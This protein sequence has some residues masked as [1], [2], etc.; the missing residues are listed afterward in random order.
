[1]Y[2]YAWFISFAL[3]AVC[4]L[5]LHETPMG[6]QSADRI[7]SS[8]L[9]PGNGLSA[10]PLSPTRAAMPNVSWNRRLAS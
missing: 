10:A 6:T 7:P 4:Y 1:M 2:H 5:V 3:S 9:V 8:A